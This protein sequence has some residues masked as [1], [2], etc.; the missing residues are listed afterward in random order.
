MPDLV[1]TPNGTF[2]TREVA[3][4]HGLEPWAWREAPKRKA[5]RKPA[6]KKSPTARKAAGTRRKGK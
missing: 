2:V 3:E 5:A 6:A 1:A 4:A